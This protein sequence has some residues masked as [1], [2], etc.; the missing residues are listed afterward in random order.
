MEEAINTKVEIRSKWYQQIGIKCPAGYELVGT[1][2][3]SACPA[4]TEPS[5]SYDDACVS[6]I[7]CPVGTVEDVTGMTCTKVPPTG[8]VE[9]SGEC[10]T[11]YTEWVIGECYINC[12]PQFLEN[13]TDCRKKII[14]R[15]AAEPWCTSFFQTVVGSTC[16]TDWVT[17]ALV[18]G[19]VLL[20]VWAVLVMSNTN[21]SAK[22]MVSVFQSS[23]GPSGTSKQVVGPAKRQNGGPQ[24]GSNAEGETID[25]QNS[26]VDQSLTT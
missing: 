19:G 22:G 25:V 2:C 8:I 11:G 1:V 23:G 4:G 17:I 10:A 14:V 18:S 26:V 24:G 3:Y 16:Q 20:I 21:A 6:T 9:T 7:A 15:R 13:G 5:T 12:P